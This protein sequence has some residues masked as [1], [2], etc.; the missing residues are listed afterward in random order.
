MRRGRPIATLRA[1][2]VEDGLEELARRGLITMPQ[3]PRAARRPHQR[4]ARR[5]DRLRLGSRR[6]SAPLILYFDTSALIKLVVLEDGS[7]PASRLWAQPVR[8]A[9]SVLAY[10]EGRAALA[11]ARRGGRLTSTGYG[12][13]LDDFEHACEELLVVGVDPALARQ[14]GALAVERGLRGSDAVHLASALTLGADATL[15]TWD[16]ALAAAA[17][18]CGCGVAPAA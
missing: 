2:D 9:S 10:P 6:R 12:R 17:A 5:A 14:A 16:T 11:A 15:V 4:P 18:A 1:V 13:A 8:A 3:R 7:D